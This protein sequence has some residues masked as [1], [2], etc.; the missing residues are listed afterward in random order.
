[1]EN[2]DVIKCFNNS[3]ERNSKTIPSLRVTQ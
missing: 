1:V 2:V 3:N